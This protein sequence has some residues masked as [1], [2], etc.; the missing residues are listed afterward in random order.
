MYNYR[1]KQHLEG[2]VLS[3]VVGIYRGLRTCSLQIKKE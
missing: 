1:K 3:V 2:F